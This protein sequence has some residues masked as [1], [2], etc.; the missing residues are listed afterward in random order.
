MEPA[1]PTAR[2][3]PGCTPKRRRHP[4]TCMPARSNIHTLAMATKR[5]LTEP[6]KKIVAARQQWTCSGCKAVLPAAYQVDHTVALCDGGADT[7]ANCTAMCPNCHAAKTQKETIARAQ[8]AAKTIMTYD[9]RVDRCLSNNVLQCTECFAKRPAHIAHTV[10]LAIEV[11][12][13]H[14][15]SVARNLAQFSF[16]P[17]YNK[18]GA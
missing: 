11:P 8:A 1:P 18:I 4:G 15:H 16:V 7:T 14:G 12:N 9:G 10:C 3:G 2:T 6:E 13:I 5:L 17:R